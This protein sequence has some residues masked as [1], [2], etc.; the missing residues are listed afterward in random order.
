M[1]NRP[2][3]LHLVFQKY[4]RPLYFVTFNTYER[5][6]LLANARVHSSLIEFAKVGE[7]RGTTLGRYVIMPDHVHL[8]VRGGID[9]VL[10]QWM[11]TLKRRLSKVLAAP[12]PHWQKGFFDHLI[13]QRELCREMGICAAK[14]CARWTGQ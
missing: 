14:S 7:Q 2:P 10:T 11:R 13:R 3:R 8:F 4:D 12:A 5:R 9:F 1:P 6:K